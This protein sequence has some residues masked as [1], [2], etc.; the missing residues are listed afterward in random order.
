MAEDNG[1][2]NAK[3]R[4]TKTIATVPT[5]VSVAEKTFEG[6]SPSLLEKRKKVVSI[7]NVKSTS[8]SAV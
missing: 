7:P 6:S 1:V 3:T 2:M 5:A 8:I 4:Q